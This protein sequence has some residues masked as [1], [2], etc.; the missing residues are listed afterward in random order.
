MNTMFL[1]FL[2]YRGWT[3][4]LFSKISEDTKASHVLLTNIDL[5]ESG[6]NNRVE[7]RNTAATGKKNK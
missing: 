6:F 2:I 4:K 1:L 3:E 7:L 5:Y